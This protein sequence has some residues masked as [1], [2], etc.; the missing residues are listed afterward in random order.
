MSQ[1]GPRRLD[2]VVMPVPHLD[3]ARVLLSSIGFTV[4]PDAVHPFGTENACVFFA[5]GTYI[6]PLGIA[7][8]E[9]CEAEAAGGNVFVA[10]DQAFRFRRGAPGFS[11]LAFATADAR[12]EHETFRRTGI[13]DGEM[14]EFR[15]IARLPNGE[16]SE[17]GFRLAFARDRRAPDL[18]LFA[19]QPLHAS[20]PDRSALTAHANGAIG[21]RRIVLSEPNPTDFQYLLQEIVGERQVL[22]DSFGFSIRTANLVLEVASPEALALRYGAS[23][24][25]ERGLRI[26]GLVLSV[27]SLEG[28]EGSCRAAG[29]AA[30][31]L[32]V[33]LVVP[34][35]AAG[36][37]FAFEAAA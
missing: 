2:H 34:L 18:S 12:A 15:R 4:A 35:G 14:L 24:D 5:D 10:H 1:P 32:D 17:L 26:E 31:R 16:A 29:L 27:E 8:R 21:L 6:E 28:I 23:R 22:A 33:R 13:G 25:E 36:A 20:K 9:R 30:H 3:D 7:E 19:C 11:G 37:F